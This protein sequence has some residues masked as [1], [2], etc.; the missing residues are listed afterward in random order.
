MDASWSNFDPTLAAQIA[1][2]LGYDSVDQLPPMSQLTGSQLVTVVVDSALAGHDFKPDGTH[3]DCVNPPLDEAEDVPENA[4]GLGLL[5]MKMQGKL[6]GALEDVAG[7]VS[8]A[9]RKEIK[10][11]VHDRLKQLGDAFS[12]PRIARFE[13]V[14]LLHQP[15][16]GIE[17]LEAG[18]QRIH[19]NGDDIDHV[20][21]AAR[22]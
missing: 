20:A 19:E 4:G 5:I 17:R 15:G 8:E 2:D 11:R 13:F 18:L 22:Q 10:Q 7:T 6:N 21:D 16:L 12:H 14:D 9:D 1:S 3:G